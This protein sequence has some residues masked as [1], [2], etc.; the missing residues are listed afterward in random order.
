MKCS[1]MWHFIWVFTVCKITCLVVSRFLGKGPWL[2]LGKIWDI[3]GIFKFNCYKNLLLCD[4]S[5]HE[6]TDD[7]SHNKKPSV[8]SNAI[9]VSESYR[10]NWFP[11]EIFFNFRLRFFC[12][13]NW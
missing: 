1:I 4:I 9:K 6:Y 12:L 10:S 8:P 2:E 3:L 5:N 13:G 11:G 7:I